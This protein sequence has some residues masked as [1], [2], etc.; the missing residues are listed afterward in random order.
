MDVQ[1][2]CKIEFNREE[3]TGCGI[4]LESCERKALQIG[5]EMNHYGVHPVQRQAELCDGCAACYY[6]CPEPGS[7]TLYP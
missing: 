4:C 1:I 7:I 6:L 5:A 3:C 2:K